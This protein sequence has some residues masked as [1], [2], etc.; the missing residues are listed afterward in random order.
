[1][2]NIWRAQADSIDFQD[3]SILNVLYENKL[4]SDFLSSEH[5]MGIS[6]TK[7]MGKTFLIKVKRFQMQNTKDGAL[8]LPKNRLADV[9]APVF[10]TS[11]QI[12]LLSNYENWVSL[13]ISLVGIYLL[14]LP[15]LKYLLEDYDKNLLSAN[16]IDLIT[17]KEYS[18]IFE[19]LSI[20]LMK[21][22]KASLMEVIKASN[23]LFTKVNRV[24]QSVCIFVDKLE[25]P[26]NRHIY[27]INASKSS[28][29]LTN[30]S[31]WSYAQVSFAEMTYRLSSRN[32]VKFYYTI[33]QEALI[34][35]EQVTREYSKLKDNLCELVYSSHELY[36]MFKKYIENE[37]DDNLCY[38]EE[39][40]NNPSKAFL[41][42]DTIPHRSGVNEKIWDYLYRHSLK[43]PRD[44]ME[45]CN[46]LCR[47]VVNDLGVRHKLDG[48]KE[49]VI[50][51]WVNE[52]ST[53]FC[54]SYLFD[55]EPFLNATNNTFSVSELISI[56]K[57]LNTNVFTKEALVLACQKGNNP[58][59]SDCVTCNNTHY[60]ST[61]QNIGLLGSIYKSNGEKDTYRCGIRHIGKSIYN[62]K[63]QTLTSG[64]L[65]YVH[66]G[67]SNIIKQE[68]DR[69]MLPFIPST[70]LIPNDS[71]TIDNTTVN[72]ILHFALS[73]WG[74]QYDR[75]IFLTSTQR[76]EM[77]SYR[78]E[79]KCFLE[80]RG[81]TVYAFEQPD[82]PVDID[83][84]EK[85][86][87]QTHDHC[88][89]VL[90]SKCRHL[91][92]LFGG[93]FGGKYSGN[94]YQRYIDKEDVFEFQ[95]SISFTEYHIASLYNKNVRVYVD[96]SV[97][98]ARAE[99]LINNK[100][101]G[102]K[103]RFSDDPERV[104]A[105]LG[106]FNSLGNGTWYDKYTSIVHLKQFLDKHFP[107]IRKQ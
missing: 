63:E 93:D 75:N 74:D 70:L 24:Q 6:A 82:F 5:S 71:G 61:L 64:I 2:R 69:S 44:I 68:T 87:G 107:D 31:I 32:H 54:R 73:R 1:M 95:P 16:I 8:L 55:I 92:Y 81:Y 9:S 22:D 99:Y 83:R 101:K 57:H 40:H 67:L 103:S 39:K 100:P 15:E 88:I 105:Q 56:F 60:F 49:R 18:G 52:N 10:L 79:I 4:V 29:G 85:E 102:Y 41:G 76:N 91:I 65:Y 33:R 96:E 46:D 47:Y 98:T 25:E 7:G 104:F 26:F 17:F 34:G 35:I 59:S 106:Y 11:G 78:E 14:S 30:Q 62:T 28:N 84:R 94:D 51:K 12:T 19:V 13:W 3:K 72:E 90:L 48:S 58:C 45:M 20:I 23:Y 37:S 66:P 80:E 42:I 43:R 36:E 86:L 21:E 77:K 38:P 50:R 27:K 89:N 97:D 53:M